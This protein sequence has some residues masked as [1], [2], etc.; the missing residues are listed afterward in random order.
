MNISILGI[1]LTAGGIALLWW[2]THPH[3]TA[4]P[5]AQAPIVGSRVIN[6]ANPKLHLM[7]EGVRFAPEDII[8]AGQ[9]VSVPPDSLQLV[10]KAMIPD[11]NNQPVFVAELK[12]LSPAMS[13]AFPVARLQ[14]LLNG[15]EVGK[16][17]L[18]GADLAPGAS[19]PF[20]IN[21]SDVHVSFDSV[22][23]QWSDLEGYDPDRAAR[24]QT[25]LT[26]QKV[27]VTNEEVNFTEHY[28]YYTMDIH[29]TVRN[30]G[31]VSAHQVKVYAILRDPKGG[32]SGFSSQD[33]AQVLGPQE[34]RDFE[35]SVDEWGGKVAKV[36]LLSVQ[37][38]PP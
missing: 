11:Q 38:T 10:S 36:Y 33:V 17:Y 37:I 27:S 18:D 31:R 2:N 13:V 8:N 30:T 19:I 35:I 23:P 28:R 32:I 34:K 3:Q 12:N 21:P 26:S 16:V 24:L 7:P 5:V 22:E 9:R 6:V 25:S 29:G 1:V 20:T 15:K 14:L 4:G